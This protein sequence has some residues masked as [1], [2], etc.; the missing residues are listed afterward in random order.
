MPFKVTYSGLNTNSSPKSPWADAIPYVSVDSNTEWSSNS[1]FKEENVSLAGSLTQSGFNA[2]ANNYA[3]YGY[4]SSPTT[5]LVF[6]TGYIK[7]IKDAFSSCYGELVVTDIP[8]VGNPTSILSGTYYIDEIQ[9]SSQSFIGLIDYSILFKKYHGLKYSGIQPSETISMRED[10]NGLVNIDHNISAAGV[11]NTFNGSDPVSFNSVKTFVQNSTGVSRL[12]SLIFGSG[13]VPTGNNA[14]GIYISGNGAGISHSSNL[15]LTTQVESIN[16]LEN[17]YSVSESFVIDN[18]RGNPYGT[19]RFSVDLNSGINDNYLSVDVICEIQGAK[20]QNFTNISGLLS[21]IT[22]EMY[23]SATGIVNNQ[24]ELCQTP[25]AFS[26]NTTRPITGYLDGSNVSNVDGSS[27]ITVNCS[28]DNSSESTFFDYEVSFSTDEITNI[29][30]LDINGTIRGRGLHASQ[31]F[32]DA[33]GYLFGVNGVYTNSLLNGHA[34]IKSMLY[35]KATGLFGKIAP[36]ADTNNCLGIIGERGGASFGFVKDKG[37]TS[38]D[39][40]TGRGEITLRGSFSDDAAVSGYNNF[41]W[42]T[43][44]EVGIPILILRPS[45]KENGFNIVQEL[46]TVDK[47]TYS[48]NGSFTFSSGSQG[49]IPILGQANQPHTGILKKLIDAEEFPNLNTNQNFYN[50][51][52]VLEDYLKT[53]DFVSGTASNSKDILSTG[54]DIKLSKTGQ[55]TIPVYSTYAVRG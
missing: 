27:S 5:D 33:S 25:I 38:L 41:N 54:F 14:S 20:D 18:L 45:Y 37:E 15:I 47:T 30:S 8:S 35:A 44:V 34:D 29:T 4:S 28:F 17:S 3:N 46:G 12:K 21:D 26:I 2:L 53:F 23:R 1:L 50:N 52:I 48:F 43:N 9:F 51:N 10:G 55:N 7:I 49:Q 16:R 31:K 24:T 11:G 36:T 19:K 6:P 22:G 42:S 39:Y 40:N 32:A 13:F